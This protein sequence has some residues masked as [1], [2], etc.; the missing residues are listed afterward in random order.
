MSVEISKYLKFFEYFVKSL[1]ISQGPVHTYPHI[2]ESETFPFRIQKIP[3]KESVF[4]SKS[5]VDT[6]S[7]VSGLTVAKPGL[8][9]VRHIGLLFVRA[10][11]TAAVPAV[12]VTIKT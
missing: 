11:H 1:G 6:H 10:L 3:A 8:H 7:M 12:R 4:K 9:V 2:F 5:P